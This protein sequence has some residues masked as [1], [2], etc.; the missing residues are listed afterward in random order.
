MIDQ[1][2]IRANAL[3]SMTSANR[4]NIFYSIRHIKLLPTF[5][6][7]VIDGLKL[8]GSKFPKTVIYVDSHAEMNKLYR[9]LM[10]H[11]KEFAYFGS[12]NSF[13]TRILHLYYG[14]QDDTTKQFI[15][16]EFRNQESTVRLV[17]ATVA[18][19]LGVDIP[20]IRISAYLQSTHKS[21][22]HV[23]QF[24]QCIGRAARDG[25]PGLGLIFSRNLAYQKCMWDGLHSAFKI[26]GDELLSI[27]YICGHQED[28]EEDCGN[29]CLCPDCICCDF[30]RKSCPCQLPNYMS[31]EQYFL[32]VINSYDL[33]E[34]LV[35]FDYKDE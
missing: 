34:D 29:K 8:Y 35:D 30:C 27:P 1:L 33:V 24:L 16:T 3:R 15:E 21:E 13:E 26:G 12:P 5:I 31:Y 25:N 4:P 23:S 22:V 10:Q 18:F 14:E 6:N 11:L 28:C 19:G 9:S 2:R 17:I 32:P 7:N 20:D